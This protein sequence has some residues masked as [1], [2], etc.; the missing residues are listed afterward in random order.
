[1]RPTGR[2]RC[3]RYVRGG[4]GVVERVHGDDQLP[5]AVARGEAAPPQALYSVRFSP[6]DL[7]GAGGEPPFCVFVDVSESYLEG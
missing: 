6:E 7:F 3:P 5:D 4:I 1:M 2:T